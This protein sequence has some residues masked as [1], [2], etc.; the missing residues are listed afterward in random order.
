LWVLSRAPTV[1]PEAYN[2]LLARLKTQGFE[3]ERL[4][5]TKQAP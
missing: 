1:N 5:R 3:L 2:A 4:E